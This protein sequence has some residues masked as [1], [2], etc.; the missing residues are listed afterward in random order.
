[1]GAFC[2]S[3]YTKDFFFSRYHSF[4]FLLL[5]EYIDGVASYLK[6][7]AYDGVYQP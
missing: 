6:E 5:T 3:I 4:C 7:L 1:M 2:S